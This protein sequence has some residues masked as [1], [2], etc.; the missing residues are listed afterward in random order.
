M[1]DS[2]VGIGNART[3]ARRGVSL[4]E[5]LVV[6]VLLVLGIL[7]IVRLYPSGFFSITSVGN[8]A[9]A[10]SLGQAAVQSQ[11]QD[12]SGLPEAIVPGTLREY[13]ATDPTSLAN[14]RKAVSYDPEYNATVEPDYAKILDTAKVV[15]NETVAIPAASGVSRQSLYVVKYGPLLMPVGADDAQ[16]PY[17]L[18]VNSPNWKPLAGS[19]TA[20]TEAV[21]T[22][23][24]ETLSP[25]Q[26][27]FLVDST[28]FKLAV[29]YAD[30]TP[31]VPAATTN[32]KTIEAKSYAQKMVVVIQA[33]DGNR[34][35]QYLSIPP[36]LPRDNT[37][38]Y[39]PYAP[40]T[41]FVTLFL[42]DT[43]QNYHGGWF[44]PVTQYADPAPPL[45]AD[46]TPHPAHMTVP[47]TD[48]VGKPITW[49]QVTVYRP[50]TGLAT[51]TLFGPDPYQYK[52]TDAN[53]GQTPGDGNLGGIL[54]N[55]RAAGG[56]GS[57][58]Q[59][60]L[61]SYQTYSW[62]ILHED[63]DVPALPAGNTTALRLTL[64]NIKRAGDPN[65]DNSIFTGM[66]PNT[67][68]GLIIMDLDTGK[69]VL[70]GGTFDP[71]A[72]PYQDEDLIGTSS[73]PK[74]INVSYATG[75]ITLG[76]NAFGDNQTGATPRTHRI[77]IFYVG[78]ADWTV[79]VQK[80]ASYYTVVVVNGAADP[81]LL[82]S[83]CAFDP[84]SNLVYFPR[85]DAGKS[86]EIDGTYVAGGA[87][88][89]FAN[90]VAIPLVINNTLG[91]NYVAVDLANGSLANPIPGSG[92]LPGGVSQVT[93]STVRGLSARSVVAWKERDR[94]K[95]HSVD[96]LLSRAQ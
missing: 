57:Y 50:F 4:I 39:A 66:I 35:T 25:G 8:A 9:L 85:S 70:E 65:P 64:K 82:P 29:P 62:K 15:L 12:T 49:Q 78:D 69:L 93:V 13:Q 38:P 19:S 68:L 94:W 67:G 53:P 26:Q 33:S 60:A 43:A 84:A 92:T 44:D 63:R 17:Y 95:I 2:S 79:A 56:S 20:A 75:R 5:V 89:S 3:R 96:A 51:G 32:V 16:A 21:P 36:A 76:S 14:Q 31:D 27:Q 58:A 73:D 23:P 81:L 40:K 28:N 30:Y 11:A 86:V 6:L 88:H 52:M 48:A 54:F 55:P 34:Y 1:K 87:L 42:A 22:L 7:I 46:G 47:A 71:T 80:A 10:D 72:Y 61:I 59:K 18:T 24:Q 45:Q 83:Q 77:R 91:S 37:N 41:G 90:T 74:A